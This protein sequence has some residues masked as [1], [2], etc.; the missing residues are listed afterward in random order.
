MSAVRAQRDES[1]MVVR[2]AVEVDVYAASTSELSSSILI[3]LRARRCSRVTGPGEVEI[4]FL[5]KSLG[6]KVGASREQWE[7]VGEEGDS[8]L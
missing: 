2:N 6:I 3:R 4:L 8:Q 5:S 7:A 1:I